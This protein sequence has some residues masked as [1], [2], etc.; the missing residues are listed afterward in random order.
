MVKCCLCEKPAKGCVKSE[1]GRWLPACDAHLS[2]DHPSRYYAWMG[3]QLRHLFKHLVGIT[4]RWEPATEPVSEQRQAEAL[5][6][7]SEALTYAIEQLSVL[8]AIAANEYHRRG[9]E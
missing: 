2:N 1:T 4:G 3:D 6:A 8:N 9:T 5:K 7:L